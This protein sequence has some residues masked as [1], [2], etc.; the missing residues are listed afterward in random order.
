M[1]AVRAAGSC[2]SCSTKTPSAVIFARICRSA[3]QETP[4]P[5]G[6]EAPWRGKRTTLAS[7][8]AT[9]KSSENSRSDVVGEVFATELCPDTQILADLQHLL[10]PLQVS[11]GPAAIATRGGKVI[12]IP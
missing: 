6:H 1:R 12:I 11:E 5:T 2:S 4:K 9:F 3:L 8:E 10:L 7:N